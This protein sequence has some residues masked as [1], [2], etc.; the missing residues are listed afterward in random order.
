MVLITG[1]VV[2]GTALAS[3]AWAWWQKQKTSRAQ[4]ETKQIQ[5]ETKQEQEETKQKDIA[6]KLAQVPNINETAFAGMTS[7][8]LDDIALMMKRGLPYA[9][10]G[11]GLTA[12]II[13]LGAKK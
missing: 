7:S 4:E 10:L 11:I 3:S 8:Q 12:L 13:V 9:L 5:E 1:M 2:G 6:L